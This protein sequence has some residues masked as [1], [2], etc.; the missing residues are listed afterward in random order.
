MCDGKVEEISKMGRPRSEKTRLAILEATTALLDESGF[1]A[2]TIESI[3]ARAGVSKVTIYKWWPSRG[4]VAIDAFFHHY[5]QTLEFPDTGDVAED[6][7]HQMLIMAAAFQGRAGAIMAEL[8]G[9][10]QSDSALAETLRTGW[11]QP[12][13]EVSSAVIRRGIERGQVSAGVDVD[14]LLDQLY[15]PIYYRLVARHSP[16]DD[17]FVRELVSYVLNGVRPVPRT[18]KLP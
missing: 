17:E 5:R 2:T 15:G 7:T 6:L 12:R 18:A 14:V 3:A 11:L 16:L 13:R 10:A 4:S 8:I 9:Q 1:A